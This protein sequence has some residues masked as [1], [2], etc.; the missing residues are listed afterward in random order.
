MD[1][2]IGKTIGYYDRNA[3]DWAKE[4]S[5]FDKGS[6]WEAEMAKFKELIPSGKILEI[7]SGTGKDAEELIRLE[8]DYIGTDASIG[9]L[10]LARERLPAADFR[11]GS[12]LDLNFPENSFDGFWTA[13]TL[14]HI[15]KDQID[16]ALKEVYKV[17]RNEGI[18]FIS[19]KRGS[20]EGED[21]LTGR[22][23]SYYSQDEFG[24][25][26]KRNNFEIVEFK[27][28]QSTKDFWL[29]FFVKVKK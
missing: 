3:T 2:I 15:P 18:G 27:E 20:T 10:A 7:G 23:F 21:S 29:I 26:L 16:K 14:L 12:A 28:R 13:A 8:Y 22:W 19:M 11:R 9:M 24:N 4:K 5:G 17:T 1:G 25:V 6:Y